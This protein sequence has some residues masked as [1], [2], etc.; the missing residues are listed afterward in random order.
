MTYRTSKGKVIRLKV[1]RKN[2]MH[3]KGGSVVNEDYTNMTIESNRG[4][5]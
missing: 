4:G 2:A 3:E 5:I 1:I